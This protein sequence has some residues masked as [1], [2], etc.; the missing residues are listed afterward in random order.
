MKYDIDDLKFRPLYA[1]EIDIRV[2]N[3]ICSKKWQGVT[4]LLY[5]NARCAMDIL[6]ETVGS[7]NWTR[8]HKEVKGNMYCGISIW[9][10]TKGQW[11]TKWDC[12]VESNTEKEKG[13]SS[14]SF[15]RSAVNWGIARELYSSPAI[16]VP[17]DVVPKSQGKGYELADKYMFNGAKV[18][19][20]AY[21]YDEITELIIVDKDGEVLF[22]YPKKKMSKDL[23]KSLSETREKHEEVPYTP[24]DMITVEEAQILKEEIE[25]V[26]YDTATLLAYVGKK[27]KC[28]IMSVDEMTKDQYVFAL[29][30]L[31]E[32]KKRKNTE[33]R[34][35]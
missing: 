12:G 1:E 21:E 10:E 32:V 7:N 17:C 27:L 30:V 2:G 29:K 16:M 34:G 26:S 8:D 25:A 3:V 18:S 4:L 20:I 14:D 19:H 23:R 11:V 15:K 5:Q 22:T 6:D 24:A 9:D 33:Q 31:E 28:T 35:S 13:E